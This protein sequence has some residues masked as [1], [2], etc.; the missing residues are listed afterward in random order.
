MSGS[1]KSPTTTLTHD[2]TAAGSGNF[3]LIVRAWYNNVMKA[4]SAFYFIR[5]PAVTEAVP[6]GL[7]PGVNVTGDNNATFLLYAPGK[8]SV[9]VL[10][11][12][13]D[14]LYCE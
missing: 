7:K 12:F 4:D 11:D 13:N 9:F 5:T 14:W 6:A 2:I 8:S 1:Q 3:K 10:G